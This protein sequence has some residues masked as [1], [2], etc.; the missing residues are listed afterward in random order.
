MAKRKQPVT[1]DGEP[2]VAAAQAAAAGTGGENIAHVVV[3]RITDH[4]LGF[5]LAD[6]A[7]ILRPPALAQMPLG[8]KSLLGLANLRGVVL[9]VVSLRRLLGLGDAPSVETAR[10]IVIDGAAPVGFLVDGID[11]LLTATADSVQKDD[12]GA[13]GIDP[14]LLDGVIKGAE[15]ADEHQNTESGTVIARR[16]C[17]SCR[18]AARSRPGLDFCRRGHHRRRR[19]ATAIGADQL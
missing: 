9:P 18:C 8:P 19:T 16:I 15:G 3:F 1:P 10:V 2:N 6:V 5:A 14:D 4:R 13:G 7:E 17:A 12:A 11:R